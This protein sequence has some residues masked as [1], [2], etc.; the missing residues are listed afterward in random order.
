MKQKPNSR[1]AAANIVFRWLKDDDFPDRILE[2]SDIPDR[3]FVM[4]VVYGIARWCRLLEW[5]IDRLADRMPDE[6]LLSFLLV[7]LYQT[8]L[9][10]NV[11]GYAAVHETVNA[12][13]IG[14]VGRASGFL[15]AIL[16]RSLR[17]KDELVRRIELLPVGTRESHPDL[18]VNRWTERY[19]ADATADLCSWNNTRPQVVVR[20]ASLRP[21]MDAFC[22]LLREAGVSADPH[23]FAPDEFLVVGRGVRVEDLPGYSDGSFIVCDPSTSVAVSLLDPQPGETVLDA[24]AAPGGKACVIA[25]KMENSGQLVALDLHEDRLSMLRRNFERMQVA[26]ARIVRGNAADRNTLKDFADGTFDGI[27]LDVPCTNTGVLRRRPDARWRFGERRLKEMVKTQQAMLD[28]AAKLVRP[29]GRI[30]YSTCSLESEESESLLGDWL[31]AN[32]DFELR[33]QV[34]LFPPSTRTDGVYAALLERHAH[35]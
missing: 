12:A 1:L 24:C 20:P 9:M 32:P 29:G 28:V 2:S 22:G 6:K 35:A 13:K 14:G 19:G 26:C 23:P 25:E 27:L 18:L 21:G 33:E 4:E 31:G 34:S 17:E 10:D 5:V 30:V 11:A 16:R 3:A 7:G 8:L 15:N